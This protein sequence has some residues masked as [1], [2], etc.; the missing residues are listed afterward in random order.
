MIVI[1]SDEIDDLVMRRQIADILLREDCHDCLAWLR[2]CAELHD[3]GKL[4]FS[5]ASQVWRYL[6]ALVTCA[7]NEGNPHGAA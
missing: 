1:D 5:S 7:S 4:G 3:E 6:Q 2:R